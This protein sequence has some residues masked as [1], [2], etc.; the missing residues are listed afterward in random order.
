MAEPISLQRRSR[1]RRRRGRTLRFGRFS[2]PPFPVGPPARHTGERRPRHGPPVAPAH[3]AWT[4]NR[5]HRTFEQKGHIR[6]T[7]KWFFEGNS[8]SPVLANATTDAPVEGYGG[9]R[10]SLPQRIHNTLRGRTMR[11]KPK[12]GND[13]L[14][15]PG[16]CRS[17]KVT[18]DHR[19]LVPHLHRICTEPRRPLPVMAINSIARPD[20]CGR[21]GRHRVLSS[22][23]HLC[24]HQP[25]K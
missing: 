12:S 4:A 10:G 19:D 20:H 23:P 14:R 22:A 13:L 7:V 5:L 24:A 8:N 25:L 2:Q 18:D 11:V 16:H 6:D 1:C 3:R 17:L 15:S 21:V 9:E